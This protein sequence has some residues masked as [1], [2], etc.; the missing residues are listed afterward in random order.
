MSAKTAF[1]EN[2]DE[3]PPV[4]AERRDLSRRRTLLKGK[5]AYGDGAFSMDCVIRDLSKTGA[6]IALAKGQTMPTRSYLIDMRSA[7]AYECV[8]AWIRAPLFGLRFVSQHNLQYVTNPSLAYLKRL[9]SGSG[10]SAGQ[11]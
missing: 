10:A 4:V 5:I 8:V 11:G 2:P 6:R 7:I 1:T 3:L 9:W